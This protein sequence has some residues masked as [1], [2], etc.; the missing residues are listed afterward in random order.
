VK[1]VHWEQVK[2]FINY[3]H[4]SVNVERVKER[5]Y[6]LFTLLKMINNEWN[7]PGIYSQKSQECARKSSRI[8]SDIWLQVTKPS[9]R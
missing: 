6:Y 7:V 2:V 5:S 4:A 3:P 8:F 1:I 9:N